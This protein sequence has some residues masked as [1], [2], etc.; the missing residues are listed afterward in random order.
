MPQLML[1]REKV[2]DAAANTAISPTSQASARSSP[3]RFGTST[4]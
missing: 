1:R 2:S 3:L 4:G